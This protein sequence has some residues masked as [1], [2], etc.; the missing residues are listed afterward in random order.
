M[1]LAGLT[2]SNG[3]QAAKTNPTRWPGA[4]QIS[5]APM[6]LF[7]CG[8]V[9]TGRGIDQVLPHPNRPH[10]YEPYIQDARDYVKLA[11]R[12]NGP[13]PQPVNF[14]YIWG[15]ALQELERV[16]PDLRIINLE[17]AI[18]TSEE[19]WPFKGIHYRMHPENIGVLTVAGID[20][21]A[22][23]NNHV[24]DWG[25]PGLEQTLATLQQANINSAG[26]GP[27]ASQAKA[28]VLLPV[29]G[30]GRVVIFSFG[31]TSS[32]VPARWA[33]IAKRPGIN[34][35]EE[36]SDQAIQQIAETT[37]T[38]KQASDVMV[39]SIHWGG[40]W[41]YELSPL[42]A[43]FAHALINEAG[44]DIVHGHSSHHPKSIEVYRDRLILYGCGDFIN[45]YEGIRGYERYR[46]D[47][48]LMY[49]PT[50][51]PATGRLLCLEMTPMRI[52]RFQLHRASRHDAQW[53]ADMLN[54]EGASLGTGVELKPNH[55]LVLTW[56]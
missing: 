55:T 6:T 12:R 14:D 37:R 35:L 52:Q 44:I 24:L 26:A 7:L 53:L 33:A 5:A 51:D 43:R 1:T 10:L 28:P 13:I 34:F 36:L 4:S 46:G 3:T 8:D 9:M 15:E 41:G 30:K 20:C 38:L 49:F 21:C 54:R 50:L 25:Y 48:S 39:A 27:N 22:L 19:P 11:E 45:D 17:T 2:T 29:T 56:T 42:Q 32:G 47:L 18:T 16:A 23:A 31:L 40:N